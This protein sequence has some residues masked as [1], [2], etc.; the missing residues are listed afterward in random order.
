MSDSSSMD[1]HWWER[2]PRIFLSELNSLGEL[3]A[4]RKGGFRARFGQWDAEGTAG[5]ERL[6]ISGRIRV[7]AARPGEGERWHGLSVDIAYPPHFPFDKLE[8]RPRD[9]RIRRRRHQERR[10]GDLCYMQEEM[11]Q[12]RPLYGL[13]RAIKGAMQW[14]RGEVTGYFDDEVPAAELLSYFETRSARIRALLIPGHAMWNTPP[15][16]YGSLELEWDLGADGLAIVGAHGRLGEPPLAEVRSMN[17]KLWTSVRRK[18][19][20]RAVPGVWFSLDTEPEPFSRLEEF[21]EVLAKHAGIDQ[22]TF[23]VVARRVLDAQTRR[24]GWLPIGLDYPARIP[25]GAAGS[26]REWLFF[27]LEWPNLAEKHRRVRRMRPDFWKQPR[28]LTGIPSHPVRREDLLR[29]V[30]GLYPTDT[31]ARAHVMV[32]GTGA[33]G[34]TVARSLTA[35]GVTRVTIVEHD[36]MK[37]G[38]VLRHEARMPDIGMAKSKALRQILLESNPYV[39]VSAIDGTRAQNRAFELAVL[40]HRHPPT[41][42]IATVAIMAV[43]GQIDAVARRADPRVP[44]LHAWVMAQSQVLRAFLYRPGITACAWC[45][46]LHDQDRRDGNP[47]GYIIEPDVK[48]QPIF[49][50]SCASPAFPGAGNSN[51]LAAHVI[52]EMALDVLH[53]RLSDAESHWVF[54]GNRIRDLD[55]EFPIP[56]LTIARRGFGSHAEC[57]VCPADGALSSELPEAERETYNRAVARLRGAA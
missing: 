49:E 2:Y 52:T 37:P 54:A 4:A 11:E 48:D 13:E 16:R 26:G 29:R 55:H 18:K 7:W 21:E 23:R 33:L 24:R 25:A 50:G 57:P 38:N 17:D 40:N 19:P 3:D 44:V 14:W 1:S 28:I 47:N 43:D 46:A 41:L 22:A 32:V 9:R 31:L 53:G 51:G 20:V 30:G 45:T 27:C 5:P 8:V 10:S 56:P 39:E 15:G 36:E 12:W 34:S 6:I 42:I 35:A